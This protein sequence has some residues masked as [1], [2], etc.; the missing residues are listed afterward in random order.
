M[1]GIVLGMVMLATSAGASSADNTPVAPAVSTVVRG[2]DAGPTLKLPL[3]L[4]D[5]PSVAAWRL[6]PRASGQANARATGSSTAAKIIGT[7]IGAVGGFYAGGA[8]GF[9]TAQDRNADDDGVSGLRGVVIGAPIGAVVGAI[10]GY[11]VA[12]S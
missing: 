10:I 12:K 8:I 6:E 4:V 2:K 7:A 3:V 5:E 11:Q 9:Y 1:N